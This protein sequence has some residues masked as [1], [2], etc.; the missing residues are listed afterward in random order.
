MST[1][2]APAGTGPAGGGPA[3]TGPDPGGSDAGSAGG[4][5]A[6][7]GPAGGGPAGTIGRP[8]SIPGGLVVELSRGTVLPGASA[9][10]DRWMAM[11]N[12]RLDE[13]VATLDRERMAVEIVFRLREGDTDHLYWVAIKGAD[14][15][16]LDLENPIDR[17]HEAQA[18]RTKTPGWVEAE[19]QVLLLPDPVR[20][21]VLDWALRPGG[22]PYEVTATVRV[23]S[24]GLHVMDKWTDAVVEGLRTAGAEDPDLSGSLTG[25]R[26]ELTMIVSATDPAAANA[27]AATALASAFAAADMPGLRVLDVATAVSSAAA[28]PA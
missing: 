25:G 7:G 23:S 22:T 28:A 16:G 20:R 18:R 19:P 15:A 9:E 13:C 1:P 5:P 8:V 6:G 12:D 2:A 27:V 11:L 14:G 26:F 24:A 10:A 3:G 21:A 4:A 17:D